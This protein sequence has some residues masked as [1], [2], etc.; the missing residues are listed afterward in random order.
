MKIIIVDGPDNTGKSLFIENLSNY[1]TDV[2][3]KKVTTIHF[4]KPIKEMPLQV[5]YYGWLMNLCDISV[6]YISYDKEFYLSNANHID[7]NEIDYVIIDRFMYSEYVYGP[8]YRG[9]DKRKT[10]QYI[11]AIE[12]RIK[13]EDVAFVLLTSSHPE[14]L[15]KMEDG[16]SQSEGELQKI[17]DE[18]NAF[19]E[20]YNLS[21][22]DCAYK[23]DVSENES[24]Y[25]DKIHILD[26]VLIN[27]QKQGFFEEYGD[28]EDEYDD[29]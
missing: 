5:W 3:G 1:L 18:I 24:N 23:I 15:V 25:K 7:K 10:I 9:V 13:K 21:I 6:P 17:Q 8:L 29:V 2:L 19:N 14:L 20:I 4:G 22:L 12:D 11:N 16:E 26:E 27:L 28:D